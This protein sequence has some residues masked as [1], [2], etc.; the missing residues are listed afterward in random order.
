M[1]SQVH[2]NSFCNSWG[3]R[4]NLNVHQLGEGSQE[5]H[6]G[7]RQ[8]QE[9][10]DS[11]TGSN[12]QDVPLWGTGEQQHSARS[13]TPFKIYRY[14]HKYVRHLNTNKLLTEVNLWRPTAIRSGCQGR[15]CF[16][17]KV[18]IWVGFG[19]FFFLQRM[20]SCT[21]LVMK[22]S[23]NVL[24]FLKTKK[25]K[26]EKRNWHSLIHFNNVFGA[27]SICIWHMLSRRLRAQQCSKQALQHRSC[28]NITS[29]TG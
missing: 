22:I 26:K 2:C 11:R 29:P 16:L 8:N 23:F 7:V 19:G 17:L 27:I 10:L 3:F 6:A 15:F 5:G 9:V 13:A 12:H 1:C 24:S 18:C 25:G 28:Y 4:N 21:T 20:Y 14:K